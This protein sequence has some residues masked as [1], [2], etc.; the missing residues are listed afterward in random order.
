M[1][2]VNIP[3]ISANDSPRLQELCRVTAMEVKAVGGIGAATALEMIGY[4]R[5]LE[6]EKIQTEDNYVAWCCYIYNESGGIQSIRT[7]N[8]NSKGAFRVY[9]ARG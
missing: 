2:I 7:C 6:I 8:S 4:I 5:E 3:D 9:K 1:P